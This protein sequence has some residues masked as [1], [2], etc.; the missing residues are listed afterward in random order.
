MVSPPGPSPCDPVV[1]FF[2][3]NWKEIT[4]VHWLLVFLVYFVCVF[5][6]LTFALTLWLVF[7]FAVI[8]LCV[9][10]AY[11]VAFVKK[12]DEEGNPKYILM[13][14]PHEPNY[15]SWKT[16]ACRFNC[17][18]WDFLGIL[19]SNLFGRLC[20]VQLPVVLR[21]KLYQLW[22]FLFGANL[23]ECE[24]DFGDYLSLQEF[25]S[26]KLKHGCRPIAASVLVSPVDGKLSSF[27]PIESD[28]IE[29]IKG[30][31]Y[32]LMQ[33][34]GEDIISSMHSNA[35][36]IVLE[37]EV[38]SLISDCDQLYP[39]V[40]GEIKHTGSLEVEDSVM[41]NQ[42]VGTCDLNIECIRVNPQALGL[43]QMVFYLA[44]GDY[45]RIHAPCSFFVKNVRH[46]P[47]TLFPISPLVARLVPNLFALNER[48]VLKGSWQYGFFALVCVG[49]YNVGSISLSFED[50]LTT[51]NFRDLCS[52]N[53]S[54]GGGSFAYTYAYHPP[55]AFQKGEE[56]GH[57]NLGSTVVLIFEAPNDAA[58]ELFRFVREET[59]G[60]VKMGESMGIIQ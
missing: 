55:I 52:P 53:L 10:V 6:S 33:F 38:G 17:L 23:E 19:S 60:Y 46:F 21:V 5:V 20:A 37:S 22:A 42:S 11:D 30:V 8:A 49:A 16:M 43:Y 15:L 18:R 2:I 54:C 58:H 40:M 25:F 4:L 12:F 7:E 45:H 48:V 59:G 29:Q 28:E 13:R 24:K 51:N 35:D 26:R 14:R 31:N 32:S 57:F 3:N 9:Y 39:I 36:E 34:L 56:V 41:I 47:G 44:P 27:G 1:R 50:S